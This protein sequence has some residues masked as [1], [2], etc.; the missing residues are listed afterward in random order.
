MFKMPK[1]GKFDPELFERLVLPNTGAK[2]DEVL[3]GPHVGH[4]NGVVDIGNDQVL[5]VTTD[6]I[7]YI[8]ELGPRDSAA[9]S[10]HLIASDLAT[11]GFSPQYGVINF[12]LPPHMEEQDFELYWQAMHREFEA[13]GCAV[14][15]GHTGRYS[16][17][18]F[19]IIGSGTLMAIGP[20]DQYLSPEMAQPGDQIILT[21]GA[22]H[23]TAGLLARV[24]PETLETIFDHNFVKRS[25]E[26]F[27]GYAT[28]HD[29]LA[30]ITAGIHDEGVT[31]MHD[32]TE[33]GVLGALYELAEGAGSGILVNADDI[34]VRDEV[35]KI[36][37]LFKL[38]PL[39]SLSEGSLLITTK[40]NRS[41]AVIDA[42]ESE[43]IDARVIG[44]LKPKDH[45]LKLAKGGNLEDLEPPE[46]DPYW[47]A[48]QRVK[49]NGWK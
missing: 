17:C 26:M 39:R 37:V 27:K 1:L 8:P 38:D 15:A 47:A 49:E 36:C 30:A 16:G 14:I 25:Q 21:K 18:D 20:K 11:S 44:E 13:L 5:V 43:D 41:G 22:M 19:T 3:H 9:I 34:L 29:S 35:Q 24:F 6:P 12:N 48:Y 4:D 42:L 32:V 31:S 46:H 45:G 10:V 33:G 28:I 23:G 40:P 2:R 7:S